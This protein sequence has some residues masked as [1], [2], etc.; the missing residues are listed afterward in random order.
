MSNNADEGLTKYNTYFYIMCKVF[1]GK[2]YI[3]KKK[4]QR[5]RYWVNKN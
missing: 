4:G 3:Y 1:V 2:V 5:Q